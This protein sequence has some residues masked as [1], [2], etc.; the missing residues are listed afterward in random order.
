MLSSFFSP[1][2]VKKTTK[3]SLK[4]ADPKC[5]EW[6]TDLTN[7]SSKK[8]IGYLPIS[9]L[10]ENIFPGKDFT[11]EVVPLFKELIQ[12][13]DIG[14]S[15]FTENE[16]SIGGGALYLYHRPSLQFALD[17]HEPL[18]KKHLNYSDVTN[19]DKFI[20]AISKKLFHEPNMVQLIK[21]LFETNKYIELLK[22]TFRL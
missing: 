21:D 5:A 22:P 10:I 17:Q 2:E 3:L 8:S 6:L 7:V 4:D 1:S 12:N 13:K 16:C 20:V 19:I 14:M 9:T 18:L 15:I 11:K